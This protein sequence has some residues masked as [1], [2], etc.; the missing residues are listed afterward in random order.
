MGLFTKA[1]E[2][3]WAGGFYELAIELGPHS[4]TRLETALR[5]VWQDARLHGCYVRRDIDPVDQQ[6]VE[7]SLPSL[8]RYGR[9]L[10]VATVPN[11]R[12]VACGTVAIRE[13]GGSDWL[14]FYLPM[15]ALSTV[16]DV[17]AFPFEDGK[18]STGWREPLDAWLA[19]LAQ[20][21]FAV[22]PFS[23]ALVGHEASGRSYA[24]EI[25]TSGV[26]AERWDGYLWQEGGK[27]CWYPPTVYC[28]AFTVGR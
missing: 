24:A 5:V 15:T 10:G 7:P 17:G 19:E 12:T 6:R 28:A 4:E 26:P 21:V 20:A 11:G 18:D 25:A 13:E 23:L 3:N 27:L 16:Y 2:D 9:L 22:A 8:E 1:I 14:D